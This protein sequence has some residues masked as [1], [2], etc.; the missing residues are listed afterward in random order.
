MD[1]DNHLEILGATSY[2]SDKIH[3]SEDNGCET[4]SCYHQC[5]T[6]GII[7]TCNEN[8]RPNCSKPFYNYK[9]CSLCANRGH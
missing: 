2:P 5:G 1:E 3:I 9:K 4:Q 8:V 6:C 7:Y